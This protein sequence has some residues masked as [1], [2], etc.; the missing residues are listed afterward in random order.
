MIKIKIDKKS[1][2]SDVLAAC[3][4]EADALEVYVLNAV[5]VSREVQDVFEKDEEDFWGDGR[6]QR[7]IGLLGDIIPKMIDPLREKLQEIAIELDLG[8]FP[9]FAKPFPT[10][11][12]IRIHVSQ[13]KMRANEDAFIEILEEYERWPRQMFRSTTY[14]ETCLDYL[15]D[16][17]RSD[18]ALFEEL[19]AAYE[20]SRGLLSR[21]NVLARHFSR[22]CCPQSAAIAASDAAVAGACCGQN[23]G[24]C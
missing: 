1:S 18:Q 8:A 9:S 10:Q 6:G 24:R 11:K 3:Y 21:A 23:K 19:S 13:K 5:E 14:I 17:Y 4:D 22:D 16:E 15:T 7:A 20:L 2:F 12:S